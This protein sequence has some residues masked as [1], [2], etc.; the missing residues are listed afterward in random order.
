MS[1]WEVFKSDRISAE[2]C[3]E[4]LTNLENRIV[5]GDDIFSTMLPKPLPGIWRTETAWAARGDMNSSRRLYRDSVSDIWKHMRL[6]FECNVGSRVQL[7][8]IP[9]DSVISLPVIDSGE[10]ERQS[11][12]L[13]LA[14]IRASCEYLNKYMIGTCRS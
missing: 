14:T 11:V 3:V 6:D 7:S 9:F 13:L 1:C 2:K 10:Q 4:H 5:R 12:A 8:K